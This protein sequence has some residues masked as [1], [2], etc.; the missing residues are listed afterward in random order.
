MPV[1]NT[2]Q[3]TVRRKTYRSFLQLEM[4]TFE[5]KSPP[6]PSSTSLRNSGFPHASLFTCHTN[7]DKISP[8]HLEPSKGSQGSVLPRLAPWSLL[9]LTD[10]CTCHFLSGLPFPPPSLPPTD[11]QFY[12]LECFTSRMYVTDNGDTPTETKMEPVLSLPGST[13]QKA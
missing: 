5:S 9:H 7:I 10:L 8:R 1:F 11:T 2:S 13:F 4:Q 3:D 12:S 6:Q